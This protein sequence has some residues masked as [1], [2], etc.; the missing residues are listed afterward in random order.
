M[1]RWA[2]LKEVMSDQFTLFCSRNGIS[3]RHNNLN[4]YWEYPW[5][6]YSA[7]LRP[8]MSILD[9]GT[10]YS[11]FPSYLWNE[12]MEGDIHAVDPAFSELEA[13][14]LPTTK[15][16]SG[17]AELLPYPDRKFDIVFCIS[18][19]EHLNKTAQLNALME[20]SRVLKPG[21]KAILTVDYFLEW[22]RWKTWS[23][24]SKPSWLP[25]TN[26]DLRYLIRQ[27]K[28]IPFCQDKCDPIPSNSRIT[29]EWFN[30]INLHKSDHVVKNLFVTSIGIVLY[31]P[32]SGKEFL[33]QQFRLVRTWLHNF[34]NG[35]QATF[36]FNSQ[37]LSSQRY[38]LPTKLLKPEPITG[39]EICE[40]FG[41][42]IDEAI[43]I[44]NELICSGLIVKHDKKDSINHNYWYS[45]GNDENFR[46]SS[47]HKNQIH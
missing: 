37:S 4:R 22:E 13:I 11:S 21:G 18:V 9:V 32:Y 23:N 43:P 47:Y 2:R 8:G 35:N 14:H 19:I 28:L 45:V 42:E 17:C 36:R 33:S 12:G 10:G 41:L 38:W 1:Y 3:D 27:S 46:L 40:A 34:N 7:G 29:N 15:L 31:K 25:E 16:S 30:S 20:F 39:I 5:A 44:I 26:V 6:F 24:C